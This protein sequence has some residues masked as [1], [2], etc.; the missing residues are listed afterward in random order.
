MKATDTIVPAFKMAQRNRPITRELLF[1][2]D[3]GARYA[4]NEPRDLLD[5]NPLVTRSMGRKGNC[6]DNAAAESFFK[7]LKA[8]CVYQNNFETKQQAAKTV[9]EYIEI[10]YN[11]KR[12]HSAPGYMP[13]QDF[14]NQLNKQIIAA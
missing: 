14:E 7:T 12:L 2:S 13:P 5:K 8:E 3:R 1:H 6:W 9:C 10:W 11:R 4:C